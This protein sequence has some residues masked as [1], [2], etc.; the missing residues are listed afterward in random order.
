MRYLKSWIV[1]EADD[2]GTDDIKEVSP[3]MNL[4]KDT[5]NVRKDSLKKIS[6]DLKEFIQKRQVIDDI[7]KKATDDKN[8]RQD[9][10]NKVYKNKPQDQGR[11]SYLQEYEYV[12]RMTR[13]VNKI[14]KS[15]RNDDI[16]KKEI[17][18]TLSDLQNDMTEA[19]DKEDIINL[20]DKINKNKDY[21][22]RV[23]SNINKNKRQLN[24]D[25]TNYLKRKRDFE[26][27]M[28][29]EQKRIENISKEV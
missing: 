16:K 19:T 10:Q 12:M 21:S 8:L 7:F 18:R 24:L 27:E 15:I 3:D 25:Q 17:Q 9:L 23:D 2:V 6:S 28:K 13:R 22:K 20:K 29:E 14:K 5:Q 11:N 26:T 4:E 1:F